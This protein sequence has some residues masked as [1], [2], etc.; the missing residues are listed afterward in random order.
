MGFMFRGKRGNVPPFATFRLTQEGSAK[1]QD[2][3][4]DPVDRILMALET[5]GTSLNIGEI[6][7]ASGL[8]KSKVEGL[9][10]ACISGGYI[11]YVGAA[12]SD[13]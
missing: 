9:I 12:T 13:V 1:V 6:A 3:R 2:F 5:R 11:T 4:G 8:K 10:P 7:E